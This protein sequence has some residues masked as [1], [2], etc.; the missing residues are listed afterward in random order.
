MFGHALYIYFS[1]LENPYC[2]FTIRLSVLIW[3]LFLPSWL[4]PEVVSPAQGWFFSICLWEV[5]T[6]TQQGLSLGEGLSGELCLIP[7]S[8]QCL[9][10]FGQYTHSIARK[11]NNKCCLFLWKEIPNESTIE[12]SGGYVVG[13]LVKRKED[14]H[15][16]G[17]PVSEN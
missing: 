10:D 16:S 11:H 5:A 2:P 1:N 8:F 14:G 3:E 12:R 4:Q 9:F 7:Y 6:L 17:G 13:E 15:N